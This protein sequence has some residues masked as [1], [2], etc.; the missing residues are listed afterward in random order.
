MSQSG[1]TR[2]RGPGY[3]DGQW[4]CRCREAAPGCEDAPF[5]ATVGTPA[6]A[7]FDGR[8]AI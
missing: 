7:E 2:F 3:V 5:R 4:L 6:D 8:R 1:H